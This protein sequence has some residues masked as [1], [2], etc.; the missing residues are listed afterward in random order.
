M[1]KNEGCLGYLKY[2]GKL[3]E[4]GY[5]DA[6]KSAQA[7]MG[8]DEAIRSFVYLQAPNLRNIDFEFP[9]IIKKGSWTVNVP[10]LI[11]IVKI[12]GEVIVTAYGVKAAQKMAE[13]DFDSF[14]LKDVFQKSLL[15][16]QWIIRIGKHLGDL[17]L[18]R[19]EYVKF[20][21]NNTVIAIKNS[22]GEYLSVPKEFIEFYVASN[23]KL[24]SKIAG[25]I[26]EERS[27]SIGVYREGKLIE[28]T[29]TK[30]YRRIFTNEEEE[31][32]ELLFPELTHGQPVELE[33]EMTRGNEM[34]NTM[35]FRYKGHIL[36]CI[37][38]QGSIVKFK[39]SLFVKCKIHG[40]ISRLDEKGRQG[41]KKPKIVFTNIEPM[42]KDVDELLLF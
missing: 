20:K 39:P 36:T 8:F 3:V 18:K 30:K 33:G 38:F 10:E 25:L 14:G 4:D 11:E 12:A 34:S 2:E 27:L 17:T 21:D 13:R 7:L 35:G 40:N 29:V 9:V 37:P 15:G 42:E 5:M 23:P 41:A 16:I 24:L 28:E 22:E 19:F 26:E 32:E 31:Q 6:R 1:D